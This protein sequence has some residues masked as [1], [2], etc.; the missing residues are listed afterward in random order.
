VILPAIIGVI[1]ERR[2][3]LAGVRTLA[4]A[5]AALLVISIINLRLEKAEG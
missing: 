4:I 3:V 5:A 1:A 2:D